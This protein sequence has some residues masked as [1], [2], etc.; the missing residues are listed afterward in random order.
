M[1]RR[2][3]FLRRYVSLI[4]G[5]ALLL[6]SAPAG[7]GK[8]LRTRSA[9]H[10]ANAFWYYTESLSP[11]SYRTTVWYVGA[12]RTEQGVWS[13][14]YKEVVR[15]RERPSGGTCVSEEFLYG[16]KQLS[17]A[18][19][20]MDYQHLVAAR[21]EATYLLTAVNRQLEAVGPALPTHVIARW[22]G[23]GNL[24]PTH[25]TLTM[26]DGCTVNRLSFRELRRP[27]EAIGLLNGSDLG[28][29]YH[30]WLSSSTISTFERTC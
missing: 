26:D 28:E 15:C 5:V 4:L 27:S 11:T 13:D 25:E 16:E 3:G 2:A 17:E 22:T 21:V 19:F 23:T 6:S 10:S 8:P 9:S 1:I 30:A 14:L 18:E 12:Y 24:D 20:E 29:T 7:A